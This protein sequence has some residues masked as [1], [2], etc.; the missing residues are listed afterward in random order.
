MYVHRGGRDISY[1]TAGIPQFARRRGLKTG[2]M[3]RAIVSEFA[4]C[5]GAREECLPLLLLHL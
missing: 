5:Q 2:T 4:H 1:S 3:E